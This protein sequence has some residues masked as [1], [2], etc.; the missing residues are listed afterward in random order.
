M[1]TE[2]KLRHL[3]NLAASEGWRVMTDLMRK[4]IVELALKNARIPNQTEKQVA[5]NSGCLLAA[6]NLLNLPQNLIIQLEGQLAIEAATT[7][8]DIADGA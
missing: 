2:T 3:K 7:T 4:E 5:F 8:A 1:K 6:E